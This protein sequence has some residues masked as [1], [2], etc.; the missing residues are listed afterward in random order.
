[1]PEGLQAALALE[2]FADLIAYLQSLKGKTQQSEVNGD[3]PALHLP[4][5]P[6]AEGT[7]RRRSLHQHRTCHHQRVVLVPTQTDAGA[8]KAQT[9]S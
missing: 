5:E 3:P 1:M 8:I 9:D 2:E 6:C 7:P 4:T